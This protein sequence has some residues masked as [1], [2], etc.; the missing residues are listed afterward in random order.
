M[1]ST[2]S[3]V[4]NTSVIAIYKLLGALWS[5]DLKHFTHRIRKGM[6]VELLEA[7]RGDA[8]I[9]MRVSLAAMTTSG[10]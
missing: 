6:Q 1:D 7:H 2:P 8:P 9:A 10:M 5:R 3:G 4:A